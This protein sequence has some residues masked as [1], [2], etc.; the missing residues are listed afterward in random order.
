MMKQCNFKA[1]SEMMNMEDG[2]VVWLV[3]DDDDDYD[4]DEFYQCNIHG[5]AQCPVSS[6][7]LN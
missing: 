2:L 5:K 6:L 3:C 4:D 1:S 7:P